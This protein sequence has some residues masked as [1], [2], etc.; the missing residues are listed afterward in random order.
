V[1][2]LLI[3]EHP[4]QVLPSLAV[5]IGLNEAIILQQI[6]YWANQGRKEINEHSWVFNTVAEWK[7]QF[8][9]W[10]E[11]TI[12][13]T[14]ASLKERGLLISEC[15]NPNRFDRTPYYR[16]DY[17]ALSLVEHA[18]LEPTNNHYQS[19][20]VEHAKLECSEG[21]KLK[22]S[23]H[24]KLVS[25][26]DSTETTGDYAETNGAAAPAPEKSGPA[27]GDLLAAEAAP[28]AKPTKATKTK[29]VKPAAFDP[30]TYLLDRGVQPKYADAWLQVRKAK[31]CVNTEV[32]FEAI[33]R[34]GA[35]AGL[36]FPDTV[37]YCAE[38][39]WVGFNP[40]WYANREQQAAAPAQRGGFMTTQERNRAI[41]EANMRAFL[42]DDAPPPDLFA[43]NVPFT[44]EMEA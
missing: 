10:S 21:S 12:R 7:H 5:K 30:M 39:T 44:I 15:L 19:E 36:S 16:I 35:K 2:K 40:Q 25:T 42:E 18:N 20:T 23:E 9:F 17:D 37:K 27:Q 8:P 43:G 33:E 11:Q 41:S 34:E 28:A 26:L 29:T 38:Q 6:H 32:A 22:C 24:A 1:S 14:I 3:N 31:R 4:L 13:R